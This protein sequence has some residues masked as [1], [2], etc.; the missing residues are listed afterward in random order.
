MKIFYALFLTLLLSIASPLLADDESVLSAQPVSIDQISTF[1]AG[2][3]QGGAFMEYEETQEW[4]DFSK[5][6]ENRW[7]SIQERRLLPMKA[8]RDQYLGP[9]SLPLFYPMGGPDVL[10]ALL[11]FPQSPEYI[12]VGLERVGKKITSDMLITAEKRRSYF[13][14]I[15]NGTSS[16]FHRSFFITKDMS[17]DFFDCGVLPTLIVLLKRSQAE[18]KSITFV[19]ITSEGD[20]VECA[21]HEA[22]GVR[23]SFLQQGHDQPQTLSYF[24]Q[25]L[26][27]Y[28][29]QHF[30]PFLK[31]KAPLA[32]MFKSASYTPHQVG[33]A[34]LV[35]FVL[36]N[37]TL[38][39]Q[40]DTGVPYRVLQHHKWQLKYFGIYD[41][42]YGESFV[43]YKQ[44]DLARYFI[45]QRAL[46]KELPFR[47]GYGYGKVPSNLLIAMP[48]IK[49]EKST[50]T[51]APKSTT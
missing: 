20:L 14:N 43:A 19:R 38:L 8:W 17:K 12:I 28:N 6:F 11:F 9:I 21:D 42:P 49:D 45:E 39:L 50:N 15:Q 10:N 22:Q 27:D 31:K 44:P 23:I 41:E 16:L 37:T 26:N 51:T 35:D 36:E 25:N 48:P 30:T 40:D 2:L 34:K 47:I 7:E 46:I 5:D 18:I 24:R 32:T 1:L 13:D 3:P 33:F 29:I 4:Q